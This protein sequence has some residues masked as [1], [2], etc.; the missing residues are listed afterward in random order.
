VKTGQF[1]TPGRRRRRRV[2]RDAIGRAAF[3]LGRVAELRRE[4]VIGIDQLDRGEVRFV[5]RCR[6]Q[7]R[8]PAPACGPSQR[9]APMSRIVRSPQ[10][11]VDYL[12]IW[13]YVAADRV[14]EGEVKGRGPNA[15]KL[16]HFRL[17]FQS[18]P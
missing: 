8:G 7:S 15:I 1:K 18:H 2:I 6:H 16:S 5:H 13:M 9:D 14:K 3:R 17:V 11:K 10:A 12:E 4:Q